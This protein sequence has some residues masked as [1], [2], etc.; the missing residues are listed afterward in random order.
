MLDSTHFQ[1]VFVKLLS[2]NLDLFLRFDFRLVILT[3]LFS[4]SF[5]HKVVHPVVIIFSEIN[6]FNW[7]F[8]ITEKYRFLG[9]QIC[10]QH[11]LTL[12]YF[13][14]HFGVLL[15]FKRVK[16]G[17]FGFDTL[18]VDEFQNFVHFFKVTIGDHPIRLIENQ[19]IN[20]R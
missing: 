19:Y 20:Q 15:L 6:Y 10:A 14:Q 1:V 7:L 3:F 5:N 2:V 8:T 11:V 4:W 16:G 9:V 18:A 12:L 13:V 17:L